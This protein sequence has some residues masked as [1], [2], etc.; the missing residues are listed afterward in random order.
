M[1][2]PLD[3]ATE[4]VKEVGELQ[5][6]YFGKVH[7]VKFKSKIDIV[8][9]VDKKSEQII[10]ERLEKE[11]PGFDIFA[12]EG[13]GVRRE[14][15]RR[16]IVDPLD[17]TVNYN[18]GYP[19]FGPSIALEL[20]GELVLGVTYI[21][22]RGELFVAEK[23]S[24]ARLNGSKIT[25]SSVNNLDHVLL[26]TGFPGNLREE[27][28]PDNLNFFAKFVKK[29]QAVRRGGMAAGDLCFVA[30][31]RLDGLWQILLSP[32]DMAAGVVLIREA[33]GIITNM[34]GREFDL[35]SGD[36]LANNGHIHEAM[37]AIIKKEGTL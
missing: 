4:L 12:E 33:G 29:V 37:L 10:V 20:R 27:G 28:C 17:G 9:D 19:Y 36:V 26:G 25:V 23:G 8:T 11:F 32:W 22:T 21:P 6:E 15:T 31:G 2:N 1:R 30:C 24:G 13:T 7:D 14:K 3:V 34:S 5:L 18:H 35:Y 16:W